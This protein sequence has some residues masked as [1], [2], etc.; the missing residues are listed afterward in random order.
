MSIVDLHDQMELQ[1]GITLSMAALLPPLIMPSPNADEDGQLAFGDLWVEAELD[2]GDLGVMPASL[3]CSA[4]VGFNVDFDSEANAISLVPVEES[5][6]FIEIIEADN[7]IILDASGSYIENKK[8]GDCI[9]IRH[10]KRVLRV[11]HVGAC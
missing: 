3:Y 5:S 7:R 2:M 11:R 6:I 10:E 4:Y 8:T 1:E 9:K